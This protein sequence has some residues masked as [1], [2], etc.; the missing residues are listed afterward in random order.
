MLDPFVEVL[1]NCLDAK[2]VKV[3]GPCGWSVLLEMT[4]F[5]KDSAAITVCFTEDN[6]WGTKAQFTKFMVC[7][8]GGWVW[9]PACT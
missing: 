3:G 7:E 8:Q 5:I 4:K 2:D 9:A 6:L 1:I